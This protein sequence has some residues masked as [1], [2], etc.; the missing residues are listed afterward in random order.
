MLFGIR[1]VP[2]PRTP[3]GSLSHIA[4]ILAHAPCAL[5]GRCRGGAPLSDAKTDQSTQGQLHHRSR[6]LR[7]GLAGHLAG[8]GE[9]ALGQ[10]CTRLNRVPEIERGAASKACARQADHRQHVRVGRADARQLVQPGKA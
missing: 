9:T 5:A 10:G 1:A 4:G 3:A 6:Q 7:N 8:R 2:E